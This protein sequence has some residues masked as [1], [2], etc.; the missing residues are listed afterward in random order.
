MP[1]GTRTSRPGY[2]H[3]RHLFADITPLRV[4]PAYRRLFL[5]A[6]LGSMGTS[7]TAVAVALQVYDI[8]GSTFSVGVVGAFA[9]VP[10]IV[11]GL[12]GGAIVDAHDRRRVALLS[13]SGMFIVAVAITAQALVGLDNAWVL[14]VLVSI[15]SGCFAVNSPARSAMIPRLLEPRLLPAA[16]ALNGLAMGLNF[17][18]GP[19][20]AGYLVSWVGYPGTYLVETVV[21]VVA[22][23]TLWSLPAMPPQGEVRRAG[24]A[25][26]W[27][28]L[29]F[30]RTR[31]NIRMTFLVDLAAMVL[32]MPRVLFP[33][34][35]ALYLGGGARTVGLLGAAIAV[36]SVLA[37]VLSGPLGRVRR[38]GR[39]V[40]VAVVCW[41]LC[42][43][44]FGF[45]VLG[46][47]PPS[48]GDPGLAGGL[49]LAIVPA[50]LLLACA[51]ACDQVSAVFRLTILQAATPDAMRGRLQGVFTVVVAGG[52]RMGDIV[53][54]ATAALLG[55]PGAAIAGGLACVLVTCLLA[56][57]WRGFVRYD[58]ENPVA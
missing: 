15:Q 44:G 19:L 47:R 3:V 57:R 23:T 16:N 43:T 39:W 4:A 31:A 35:G 42:V 30:L 2:P 12:Y 41:G 11:L 13:A 10:L 22:L 14:Y 56:L 17:M 5:G 36:G 20:L 24:L 45:T 28:G 32:A 8:T 7:V 55:E 54:G 40:I 33:A 48:A 18:L 1:S 58:A 6:T 52:P 50:C 46:A 25:S 26:V 29:D 34:L 37:G 21:L 27:E 9:V 51:G 53:L 49:S 38:Q